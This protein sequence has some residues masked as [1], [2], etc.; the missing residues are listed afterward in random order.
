MVTELFR[1]SRYQVPGHGQR[2]PSSSL[3]R[4]SPGVDTPSPGGFGV[5]GGRGL[6][7]EGGLGFEPPECGVRGRG[8][9]GRDREALSLLAASSVRRLF[10]VSVCRPDE[11]PLGGRGRDWPSDDDEGLS[12]DDDRPCELY[13]DL[14]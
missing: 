14:P 7:V 3:A 8:G 10:P 4:S 11:G 13:G 1:P 6:G 2:V 5:E 9:G 12:P